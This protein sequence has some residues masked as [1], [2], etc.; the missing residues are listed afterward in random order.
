MGCFMREDDSYIP[1]MLDMLNLRFGPLDGSVAP[2]TGEAVGG[3]VEMKSLQQ[4]FQIFQVGRPFVD[5]ARI[6][7]LGGMWNPR[8]KYRWFQLLTA[9]QRLGSNVGGQSGDAAIVIAIIN[10]LAK[11]TPRPIHFRAHDYRL[12]DENTRVLVDIDQHPIFYLNIDFMTIS[13]PMSPA[14]S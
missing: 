10:E 11:P 1:T 4:E 7:N 8:A 5:S 12:S 9:L 6:L 13:I 2:S 14:G 3:I